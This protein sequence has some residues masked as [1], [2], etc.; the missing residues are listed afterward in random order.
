MSHQLAAVC[1]RN[2]C[3]AFYPLN[4]RLK[5]ILE[6]IGTDAEANRFYSDL[7]AVLSDI[8]CKGKKLLMGFKSNTADASVMSIPS[9]PNSF[10]LS[11][12][13]LTPRLSGFA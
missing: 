7:L 5:R 4:L 10:T 1:S 8:L 12:Q 3:Q 11:M 6:E 2:V 9:Q 13:P